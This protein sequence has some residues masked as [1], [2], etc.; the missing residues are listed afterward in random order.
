MCAI[1]LNLPRRMVSFHAQLP[2]EDTGKIFKRQLREPCWVGR[3]DGFEAAARLVGIAQFGIPQVADSVCRRP[4][5]IKPLLGSFADPLTHPLPSMSR[6]R[7]TLA[8]LEALLEAAC[9]DLRG[10]MDGSEYKDQYS[11]KFFFVPPRARWS[12]EWVDDS[13]SRQPALKHVKQNVG[14]MLNKALQALEDDNHDAPSTVRRAS[15]GWPSAWRTTLPG[16]ESNR[17]GFRSRNQAIVGPVARNRAVFSF[18]G[19]A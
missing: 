11:G 4:W 5:R 17:A 16:W 18:T 19:S 6:T 14:S 1:T 10:N 15:L 12:Q 2:R 3:R 9:N 13:G 7:L 8:R